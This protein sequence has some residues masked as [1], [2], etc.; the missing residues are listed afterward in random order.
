MTELIKLKNINVFQSEEQYIENE[1]NL[2][3]TDLNLIPALT[4]PSADKLNI[5]A[6]GPAKPVYFKNGIPV[7]CTSLNLEV[8]GV[9]ESATKDGNGNVITETYISNLSV[10]GKTI[11]FTKGNGNIGTITTQD[12]TYSNATTSAAGLMSAADK[13]KLNG[14]A[15]GGALTTKLNV[16]V[17]ISGDSKTTKTVTGL[18]PYKPA[19]VYRSGN[20]AANASFYYTSSAI[21]VCY[22]DLTTNNTSSNTRDKCICIIPTGTSVT[23]G[24]WNMNEPSGSNCT[25]T[26]YVYQ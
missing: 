23:I 7:E 1:A 3:A 10:S 4:V 22:E 14:F 18:T 13:T 2:N 12:T 8:D 21:P 16:S 26:L 17:T 5:D 20:G 25:F 19:W 9:S 15:A 11:T 24:M 6:G